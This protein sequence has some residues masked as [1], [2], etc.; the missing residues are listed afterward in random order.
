MSFTLNCLLI[1]IQKL[2]PFKHAVP[3][4]STINHLG[5]GVV[6]IFDKVFFSFGDPS[7]P[8]FSKPLINLFRDAQNSFFFRLGP[9]SPPPPQM[10][11]GLNGPPLKHWEDPSS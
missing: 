5:G 6:Q 2:C 9:R 8:N 7:E 4:G 10:I 3:K 1:Y 11:N